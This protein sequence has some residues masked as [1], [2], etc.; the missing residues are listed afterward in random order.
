MV[1]VYF[2]YYSMLKWFYTYTFRKIHGRHKWGQG[3]GQQRA[4][5]RSF[6]LGAN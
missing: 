4:T 6:S 1:L 2:K 5:S 3:R